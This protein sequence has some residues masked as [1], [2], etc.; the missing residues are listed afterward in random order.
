MRRFRYTLKDDDL[1]NY[2]G[3]I[4][5]VPQGFI[6]ATITLSGLRVYYKIEGA[7]ITEV[8]LEAIHEGAARRKVD[9]FHSA[10]FAYSV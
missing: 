2:E 10:F 1:I 6:E 5:V 7:K 9:K 4:E 3:E 8:I